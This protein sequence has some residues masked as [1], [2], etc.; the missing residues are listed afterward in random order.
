MTRQLE[1]NMWMTMFY[2][3]SYIVAAD[4]VMEEET[5]DPDH[6]LELERRYGLG[7]KINASVNLA[8]KLEMDMDM[9]T[10]NSMA[11]PV[12]RH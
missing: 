12:L 7:V 2:L 3:C 8:T 10:D 5:R 4:V 6:G 9:K 11:Q 1:T